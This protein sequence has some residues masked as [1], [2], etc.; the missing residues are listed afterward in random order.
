MTAP[1]AGPAAQGPPDGTRPA[2]PR[3][4]RLRWTGVLGLYRPGTTWLHRAPTTAKLVGLALVGLAVLLGSGPQA[5]VALLAVVVVAGA[6]ARPPWRATLRQL[7]P[8]LV[9]AALVGAYQWWR[10]G[11]PVAVEVVAD[12]I[13]VVLAATILTVTTP[14]D[15]LLDAL[16]RAARPLRH[17]G[18]RPETVAL[19]VGLMLRAVP[20]L[21]ETSL[22]ARDAARARGLERDPRALLVPAAVRAVGRARRTGDALAARG[23]AD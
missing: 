19:A 23:I 2:T 16:A 3:H 20:A 14:A 8:V 1:A 7:V 18:L 21:V 10:R 22:E 9:V 5:A 6:T 15:Q 4:Q 17:V 13:T 12:L 11:G